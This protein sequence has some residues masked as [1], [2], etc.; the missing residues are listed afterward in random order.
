MSKKVYNDVL[1]LRLDIA[2]ERLKV[3]EEQYKELVEEKEEL[4]DKLSQLYAQ[5][6]KFVDWLE[7][8][9]KALNTN[10][11]DDEEL[12]FYIIQRKS[13]F[14]EILQKYRKTIGSTM[15]A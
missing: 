12:I 3:G 11:I 4:M 7:Q 10:G 15:K 14:E 5:E 13:A 2:E 8:K 6:I 1:E 9:L